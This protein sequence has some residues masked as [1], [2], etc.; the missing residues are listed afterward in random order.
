[1]QGNIARNPEESHLT[2]SGHGGKIA[3][4]NWCWFWLVP[5]EEMHTE[6]AGI[7]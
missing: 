6:T 7:A 1:M 3:T 4:S 2:W 5:G